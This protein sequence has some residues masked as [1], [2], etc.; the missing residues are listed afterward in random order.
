MHMVR[1]LLGRNIAHEY[2]VTAA[3]VHWR[4]PLIDRNEDRAEA[5]EPL[6]LLR[7][8]PL[9]RE[10]GQDYL[11]I[12]HS[13]GSVTFCGKEAMGSEGGRSSIASTRSSLIDLPPGSMNEGYGSKLSVGSMAPEY[14]SHPMYQKTFRTS[15][16]GAGR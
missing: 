1:R 11:P 3:F 14:A 13:Q 9:R 5:I 10:D 2:V 4:R 12:C 16:E 15:D 7:P 6:A 8:H